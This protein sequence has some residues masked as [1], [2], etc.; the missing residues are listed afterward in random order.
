[1]TTSQDKLRGVARSPLGLEHPAP[2]TPRAET[3]SGSKSSILQGEAPEK[4]TGSCKSRTRRCHSKTSTGKIAPSWLVVTQGCLL[5]LFSS[6]LFFYNVA[7]PR[8]P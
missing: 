2:S 7:V 1:M 5:F 4:I 8:L 3:H 6:F